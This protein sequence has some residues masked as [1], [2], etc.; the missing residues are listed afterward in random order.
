MTQQSECPR[1]HRVVSVDDLVLVDID[2]HKGKRGGFPV[3]R[4]CS[5]CAPEVKKEIES[6][7][8]AKRVPKEFGGER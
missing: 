7:W 8:V 5:E 4:V 6:Q 3:I 1:C 2:S